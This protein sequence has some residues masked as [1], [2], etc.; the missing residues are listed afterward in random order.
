MMPRS[1]RDIAIFLPL[2]LLP[3]LSA[4][5]R[6][7]SL[8]P[9]SPLSASLSNSIIAL[10]DENSFSLNPSQSRADSLH[11]FRGA[12]TYSPFVGGLKDA[13]QSSAEG[14]YYSSY[15][16]SSIGIGVTGL[17]YSDLYSDL[18]VYAS[19]ARSFALANNRKASVGIRLRYETLSTTPN[20]PKL[21]FLF[22][23]IGLALDLTPEFT[24]GGTALNLLGAKYEI[25]NGETENL[26]RRFLLGIAYHPLTIPIKLL[27]SLEEDAALPLTIAFG[28]EYDPVPFLAVRLGT[29]TDTGN[30]TTGIG[31]AY[32]NF[33]F[34]VGSRFDKA[35]GSVFTFGASGAW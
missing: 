3:L 27:T 11:P 28:A 2:F 20:Y 29:S 25:V 4:R 23:D 22:A 32:S 15:I 19:L 10:G 13:S 5:S 33:S 8:L 21:H 31:I 17:S 1:P 34:D 7:Q 24:L 35:L 6:S 30:I 26:D 18:S 9:E 12:L 14:I 16:S